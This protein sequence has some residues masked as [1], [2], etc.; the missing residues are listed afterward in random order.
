MQSFKS[1]YVFSELFLHS[2]VRVQNCA[3]EIKLIYLD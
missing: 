1:L 2:G 3:A